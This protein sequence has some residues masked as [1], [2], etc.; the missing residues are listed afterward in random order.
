MAYKRIS[1]VP[2]IEGGTQNTSFTAFGILAAGTTST[3]ALQQVSGTG[4]LNQV[5]VSQGAESLPQWGAVPATAGVASITGTPN[6][7][8]VD[9]TT[10]NVTG[11]LPVVLV[12]PG[13]VAS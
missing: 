6:Q 11:S 10:G 3:G 13:S 9:M 2:V 1:P 4:V 5:L 12:A 8:Q 7:W